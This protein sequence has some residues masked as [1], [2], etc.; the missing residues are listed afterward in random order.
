MRIIRHFI[1]TV[2]LAVAVAGPAIAKE[3]PA[4]VDFKACPQFFVTG[5]APHIPASDHLRFRSLCYDAF[6][7]LHS[8]R[9][10]TPVFVAQRLNRASLQAAAG[11]KRT[12]KFF[13]DARLPY[14]E[15]AQLDDYKGSGFDRG[16]M[17]PAGD[18]P[19]AQAMAQ[20]F[21]L[22]NMVPQAPLNNQRSWNGIEQA[23]RKYVLRAH[24]DVYV[25][26]G[27]V[28]ADNPRVIGPGKVWVPKYLYKLVYDA[29][30]GRAWAHWMEN[31]DEARAGRPITYRELV[32]RTGIEFLPGM[33][34][35]D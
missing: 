21:S 34:V 17:A 28:F 27:P 10:K 23:T 3:T 11:E 14:A 18:M 15:R 30:T 26:T 29:T 6:A 9:S 33:P 19:A 8:G 4:S 12:N 16:H 35:R 25:I 22:A 32:N 20:S 2:L 24:G 1:T 5:A 13:A 31:T 7:V